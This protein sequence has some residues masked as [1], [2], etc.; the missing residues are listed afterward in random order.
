MPAGP[1]DR[2]HAGETYEAFMGRWSRPLAEEFVR[3]LRP[4]PNWDWLDVGTG[5]GA[6]AGALC[7]LASPRSVVGCDASS[8]F[9]EF[10]RSRSADPCLRF[11]VGDA[12]RPPLRDGG[13]D[14]IVSGLALNFFPDP[15]LALERQLEVA[16][17]GGCVAAFVWDYADGM[18]FLRVFWDA[19]AVVDPRAAELDEGRR[20][21]LCD[22]GALR[23]LFESV[24]ARAV[25]T[26]AV[27]ISTPFVDFDDY[28]RPLLGGVGPAPAFVA[29]LGGDQ[30]RRLAAELGTRLRV[31]FDGPIEL[32]ARAWTV[33]GERP[34]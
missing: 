21:P 13:Y 15:R 3:W 12:E 23:S 1:A 5:T 27:R 18:E 26:G 20:F 17:P 2:W 6:L 31:R 14:A 19:A 33:A 32:S 7:A 8:A 34:A 22:P 9:V 24:G 11:E 10:A 16:R 29:S 25:R 28:W 30:R 4:P